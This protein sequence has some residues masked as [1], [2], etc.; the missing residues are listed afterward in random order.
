MQNSIT[1]RDFTQ[2]ANCIVNQASKI[3]GSNTQ[4]SNTIR[5]YNQADKTIKE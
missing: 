4:D 2:Q 1:V 5:K 3:Q